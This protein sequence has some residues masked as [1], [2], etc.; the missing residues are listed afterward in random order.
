[1]FSFTTINESPI[2]FESRT[3]IGC[4]SRNATTIR[5]NITLFPGG[6]F[7][8]HPPA[9]AR[10]GA[11]EPRHKNRTDEHEQRQ[12]GHYTTA[13]Y[14]R[15]LGELYVL[16]SL[17]LFL[18]SA[19]SYLLDYVLY[20]VPTAL[21][22]RRSSNASIRNNG[23][24]G[25]PQQWSDCHSVFLNSGVIDNLIRKLNAI[26]FAYTTSQCSA[27]CTPKGGGPS[28]GIITRSPPPRL[29]APPQPSRSGG[30]LIFITKI[31]DTH[32]QAARED[33]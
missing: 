17:A 23:L 10:R 16:L 14:G 18:L 22:R 9:W 2:G 33:A 1:M 12:A 28:K 24:S 21:E 29:P 20:S 7:C 5:Y 6:S 26:E 27:P 13:V 31:N 19:C 4:G 11:H 32:I 25:V 30:S 3:H 8:F 15:V